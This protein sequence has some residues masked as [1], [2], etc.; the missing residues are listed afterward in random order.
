MIQA[1]TSRHACGGCAQAQCIL[2]RR[3]PDVLEPFKY[4]GYPLLLAAV[5]LPEDEGDAPADGK[6]AHFLSP[7]QAP[8]LQ[9]PPST[10][11]SHVAGFWSHGPKRAVHNVMP[12]CNGVLVPDL[13][14]WAIQG[15]PEHQGL[16][17]ARA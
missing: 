2:F 5:T 12:R 8:L 17:F 16:I 14:S 9:V 15:R 10:W 11:L 1:G 3:Y 13:G 4:G 6:A 7:E